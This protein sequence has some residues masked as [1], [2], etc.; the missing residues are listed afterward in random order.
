MFK[1]VGSALQDIACAEQ[2]ATVAVARGLGTRLDFEF[3][4]KQ[5]IGRNA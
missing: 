2:V 5:S 1:S 3:E 4:M